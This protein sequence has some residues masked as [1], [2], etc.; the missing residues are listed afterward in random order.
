MKLKLI[1]TGG[2]LGKSKSAVLDESTVSEELKKQMIDFIRSPDENNPQNPNKDREN[3]Y[4]VLE[5]DDTQLAKKV[6]YP[7]LSPKL[8]EIFDAMKQQLK[9]G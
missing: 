4:W 3:Y 8:K 9:F 5:E 2:F 6:S 1:E 7:Q